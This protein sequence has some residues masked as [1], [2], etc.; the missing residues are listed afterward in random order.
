MK[1][2]E[3][4]SDDSLASQFLQLVIRMIPL[5]EAGLLGWQLLHWQVNVQSRYIFINLLEWQW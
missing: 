5:S 1:E 2:E 4:S 3:H